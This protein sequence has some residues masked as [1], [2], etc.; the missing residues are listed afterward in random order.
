MRSK[1][2][3]SEYFGI[4]LKASR[5]LVLKSNIKKRRPAK[6]I[7]KSTAKTRKKAINRRGAEDAEKDGKE[8]ER[9]WFPFRR[10][11]ASGRESDVF[12]DKRSLLTLAAG[13][14]ER[15]KPGLAP[16]TVFPLLSFLCASAVSCFSR[17]LCGE[18][19]FSVD[20]C[21]K[22]VLERRSGGNLW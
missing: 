8:A 1:Q 2:R 17:R 22:V 4:P 9:A 5:L 11:H 6:K 19:L 21:K 14:W 12:A 16:V 10:P 15:G 20:K 13:V 3:L 7:K 18:L